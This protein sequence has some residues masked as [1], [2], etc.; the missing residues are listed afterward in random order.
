MKSRD[1]LDRATEDL[2]LA[3]DDLRRAA[4][5]TG[6]A[7]ED[8]KEGVQAG[9][10]GT[11]ERAKDRV[12]HATD[13]TKDKAGQAAQQAK[14]KARSAGRTSAGRTA[15]HAVQGAKDADD[16]T[17]LKGRVAGTTKKGVGKAGDV[18]SG[19]AP[20]VGRGA[21]AV[22]KGVGAALHGAA[23]PLGTVIGA[24]AGKAGGWWKGA[25]QAVSDLPKE[26]EQAC[27]VHFEAYEVKPAGL[28]W[29]T[30]R[31]GYA[32]GYIAGRNPDYSERHFDDVE[33]DL[34]HGF[35]GE[36]ASGYNSLRDFARYGYERGTRGS[37]AQSPAR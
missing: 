29:E 16:N 26:E 19:A 5:H 12:G 4:G 3:G 33:P 17:A 8:T 13:Q 9:A 14:E 23:G 31:T 11:M 15:G 35:T 34:R 7:L 21:E 18:V 32:I 37:P 27:R 30:A 28:E 1:H 10:S 2:D 25:S 36:Q 24:I 22:T 6:D 20:A